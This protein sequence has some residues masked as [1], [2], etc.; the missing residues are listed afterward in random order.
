MQLAGQIR[1]SRKRA[2]RACQRCHARKVRCDGVVNG[3]PCTN[4]RLDLYDCAPWAPRNGTLAKQLE[5]STLDD[6]DAQ[7][8]RHLQHNLKKPRYRRCRNESNTQSN[9]GMSDIGFKMIFCGTTDLRLS[10]D[11]LSSILLPFSFYPFIK[12]TRLRQL[13]PTQV[14]FLES[15]GCLHLPT[16]SVTDMFVH[17]YFLY[18]H[19]FLPLLD[20]A[21]F[22]QEY[23]LFSVHRDGD[24]ISI[25]LFHTMLFAASCVGE[26]PD[27]GNMI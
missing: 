6:E 23:R 9:C 3:F 18:V 10:G 22:W 25:L 11:V 2:W 26:S 27:H 1:T 15:Q 17:N 21:K 24:G 13:N 12:A 8:V 20:E 16:K 4:C 7:T 5:R 19:P 14:A